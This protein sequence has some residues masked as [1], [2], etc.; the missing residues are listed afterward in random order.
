[1]KTKSTTEIEQ[2]T[3]SLPVKLPT[4]CKVCGIEK[5]SPIGRVLG[6]CR[7]CRAK[8]DVYEDARSNYKFGDS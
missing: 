1:M 2:D 4:L 8:E 5:L 7:R 6:V 3:N